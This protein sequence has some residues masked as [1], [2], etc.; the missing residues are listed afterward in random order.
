MFE[1]VRFFADDANVI[2]GKVADESRMEFSSSADAEVLPAIAT[3][4]PWHGDRVRT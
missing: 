1:R 2:A 4:Q 3:C